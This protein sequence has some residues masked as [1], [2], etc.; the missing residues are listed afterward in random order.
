[1]TTKLY[2]ISSLFF[3][4][5]SAMAEDVVTVKSGNEKAELQLSNE[6]V[7]TIG[8][9]NVTVKTNTTTLTFNTNQRVVLYTKDFRST[10]EKA[11][12]SGDGKVTIEDVSKLVNILLNEGKNENK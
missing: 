2:L 11:D 10:T 12:V 1:M 8:G 9:D 5:T 3:L 4:A 6:P 7:M